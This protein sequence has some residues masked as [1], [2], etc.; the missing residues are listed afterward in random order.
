MGFTDTRNLILKGILVFQTFF[1]SKSKQNPFKFCYF[2]NLFFFFNYQSSDWNF[3]NHFYHYNC[4]Y[5]WKRN[6]GN[7]ESTKRKYFYNSGLKI[8]WRNQNNFFLISK[9]LYSRRIFLHLKIVNGRWFLSSRKL[10]RRWPNALHVSGYQY[11][12]INCFSAFLLLLRYL[13]QG[14][15]GNAT[16]SYKMPL[17]TQLSLLEGTNKYFLVNIQN[18]NWD[19]W[20]WNKSLSTMSRR[21]NLKLYPFYGREY[22]FNVSIH[23]NFFWDGLSS[24]D[25]PLLSGLATGR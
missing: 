23:I 1:S 7:L 19:G 10:R 5:P 25:Y 9:S 6:K 14:I 22:V 21:I 20:T 24:P 8:Q 2:R 3:F 15:W 17:Y 13:F 4:Y 18:Y 11:R 12:E 16:F